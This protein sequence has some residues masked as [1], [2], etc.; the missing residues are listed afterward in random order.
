MLPAGRGD[1]GGYGSL[2][3]LPP[4]NAARV[5]GLLADG[6]V[7]RRLLDL[8]FVPGTVVRAVCRSPLGDP[9]AYSVR[10]TIIALRGED[11]ARILIGPDS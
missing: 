4:G 11:A 7:R 8:G 6:L 1:F 10:G 2:R 3:L 5:T 9:T